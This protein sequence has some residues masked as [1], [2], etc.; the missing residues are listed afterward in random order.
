LKR[1]GRKWDREEKNCKKLD[2]YDG[3]PIVEKKKKKTGGPE[4]VPIRNLPRGLR[5]KGRVHRSLLKKMINAT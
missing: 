1:G 4:R 2:K 3:V 5:G